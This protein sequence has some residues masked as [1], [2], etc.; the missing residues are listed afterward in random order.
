M[1]AKLVGS[2]GCVLAIAGFASAQYPGN[3]YGQQGYGGYGGYGNGFGQPG[4]GY[5]PYGFGAGAQYPQFPSGG[6]PGNVL[7]NYFNPQNQPLSPYLNLFR[8]TNPATN[9]YYGVRPG[10]IGG[11]G[12]LGGAPNIAPGGF[13]PPFFPQ[14]AFGPDPLAPLDSA[15][16]QGA[17]LPPAGHPVVFNNT[18]GYFPGAFGRGIRP[19]L[20]GAGNTSSTQR[21]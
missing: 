6:N 21:R 17:T 7:P 2:M 11:A 16:P 3:P 5:S 20:A 9:Y 19:G 1:L 12:S 18:L 13:R 10:T 15:V 4:A 8:N 14:L